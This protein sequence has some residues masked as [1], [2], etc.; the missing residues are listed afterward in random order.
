MNNKKIVG[1]VV[2]VPNPKLTKTSQLINDSGFVTLDVLETQ[3]V[4]LTEYPTKDEMNEAIKDAFEDMGTGNSG[5]NGKDGADG[6]S[7]T[8]SWEGT[9]LTITSASGTSSA[10]LKGDKGEKGDTGD[11]GSDG[12]KGADGTSVTVT[13]VSTSTADGGSNVVTF[14]DGKTLTV[15]NGSKGSNGTNGIDGYTPVKGIDYWR[16]TDK[17]EINADNIAFISTELA[18]RGQLKPEFANSVEECTDTTKLYVLPDGY[19]YGYIKTTGTIYTNQLPISTDTDGTIF[20]SV[21]YKN[22]YRLNSGG[23]VVEQ[24]TRVTTGFIP[25]KKGDIIYCK[26]L[27]WAN[28]NEYFYMST[29]K[30]TKSHVETIAGGSIVATIDEE[31]KMLTFDTSTCSFFRDNVEYIRL[32]FDNTDA[33][34]DYTKGI[35]TVNEEIKTQ[36]INAWASTGHTFVPADYEDRIIELEN[37]CENL[38]KEIE[39]FGNIDG[40]P[41]Y[42]LEEAERVADNILAVRNAKSFVFGAVSD[43][44]TTGSDVSADGVLHVGMG[45]DAINGYTQLDAVVNFGD[46]IVNKFDDTYKEGFKFVK[47]AFHEITKAV[48]YIHLQGNHDE[49][50][51]DTT[52]EAQQKYFAYIG[53]NN[54]NVVTDWS[55]RFRNYGYK[56][57]TDQKMRFIYLNSADVSE[58]E[59]TSDCYITSQQLKWFVNTALD[60]TDK[61]DIENWSYIVC[62]HHPLNWNT[63][64]NYL[65][66][67]LDAYKGKSSGSIVVD[68]E[69][70]SF[71]FTNVKAEFIAHLHGHLH[72]FRTET[73]GNNDVLTITIP[74]A[75]F[76]RNNEYGTYSGYSESTHIKFGDI[77]ENGNQRQFNKTSDT[78]E[79]TAFNVIV[80]DRQNRKIHC[81]N[82]GAG[83]DREIEY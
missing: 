18:K 32:C 35:I 55:N 83:I 71:D 12:A 52:E 60:F 69:T 38:K 43:T 50:S 4:D 10:D 76:N 1:N 47:T 65:L 9:V 24:S 34:W 6:V 27:K 11:K 48:P 30:S 39:N 3:K 58:G 22:G 68:G 80:I 81:F 56:D 53:A 20:N 63:S 78:A 75:C 13:N 54:V 25:V 31:N 28:K 44:H 33:S 64:T 45:M 66:S 26:N 36:E 57:F 16:D 79:D 74:N 72:N 77:D 59:N 8:H 41:N 62:C 67:L 73:L 42:V 5:E 21:G 46:I 70:I 61:S 15:K 82:Y 2:G 14:S 29:Y 51:A 7:C 40:I 37:E 19:I 23:N 49:L 17:E